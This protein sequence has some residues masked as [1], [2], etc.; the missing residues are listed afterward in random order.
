MNF[1]RIIRSAEWWEYKLPPLLAIG[2]ATALKAD[3]SLTA[4]IPHLL[5]LLFSLIIGAIYVSII[6]DIT[7]I[8]VD[9][10]SNKKNR[11]AGVN[12]AIRWIFPAIPLLAGGLCAYHLYPDRLSIVLY[13]IPWISFSL[14]SI[15]PV[16]LKNRGIWGVFADACGSHVF[17]SLLMISSI[18]FVTKQTMDWLWFIS[19]GIWALCYG[20]RGILW[21]QFY[22]RKNDIQAKM[23]T[24]AVKVEP[25]DF[26]K[27]EVL[28]FIIEMLAI[29][30]M[31]FSIQQ[32]LAV[33]FLLLYLLVAFSR[34]KHLFYAPVLII[35]PE[36]KP[37]HILMA[38]FYQV[39][40]PLSLLITAAI[41]Q[42]YAWIVL[43]VHF[44]LFPQKTLTALKDLKP[45]LSRR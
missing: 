43:T 8:K 11:M 35:A 26:R 24:Y 4:V 6:N 3:G 28:I 40:L 45:F 30:I 37:Y 21:H 12:P 44:I 31:L 13:L 22:D 39:F 10:A 20:M 29:V 41:T 34:S 16:R 14:Y 9:A 7:D 32:V 38:D 42:P 2:Y 17:T 1:L 33:A 25:K 5:F 27:K 15:P 19:T 18:S 36:G 23:N